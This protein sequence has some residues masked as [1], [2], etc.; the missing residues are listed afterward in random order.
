MSVTNPSMM[1]LRAPAGPGRE[2]HSPTAGR[3]THVPEPVHDQNVAGAQLPKGIMHDRAVDPPEA[4]RHCGPGDAL[5]RQEPADARVH[6][7]GVVE[8]ADGGGL[9]A[10]ENL[11][12]LAVDLRREL[13]QR[14]HGFSSWSEH[15]AG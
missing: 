3:E 6:E 8:M 2:G 4:D 10:P 1:I 15:M 13:I 11:E 14:E 5:V 12:D 7:A 9:G